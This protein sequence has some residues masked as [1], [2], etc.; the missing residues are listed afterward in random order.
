MMRQYDTP[1]TSLF[2]SYFSSFASL[3]ELF[4]FRYSASQRLRA[5]LLPAF[6]LLFV[7]F[8]ELS[9]LHSARVRDYRAC[10]VMVL[11]YFQVQSVV[12]CDSVDV[13]YW[14][15][16]YDCGYGVDTNLSLFFY[17][18]DFKLVN[19]S[20]NAIISSFI[21]THTLA[22]PGGRNRKTHILRASVDQERRRSFS[23]MPLYALMIAR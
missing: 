11:S 14:A 17:R 1:H 22:F 4:F 2:S 19:L 21:H 15:D 6:Y 8:G 20:Y 16:C 9:D 5:L 23:V 13:P 10:G 7:L 12:I 18:S 3:T